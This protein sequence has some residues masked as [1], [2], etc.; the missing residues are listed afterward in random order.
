MR[1]ILTLFPVLLLALGCRQEA[2]VAETPRPLV[3]QYDRPAEYFEEALPI[4]NGRIGA[5][6]YGGTDTAV[7]TLNDITLWTGEPDRGL[8]HMDLAGQD[9]A[10]AVEAVRA[11]LEAE[12]YPLAERLQKRLQGHYSETYQPLGILRIVWETPDQVGGD[13]SNVMPGSDRASV[14][15]YRRELNISDA[16]A[17]V[18]YLRD[19]E[20]FT[21][22]AFASAPDSA[23]V[24]RLRY[25][26]GIHARISFDSP[27]PGAC[28]EWPVSRTEVVSEGGSCVESADSRT[29]SMCYDGYVAYHAY[30]GYYKSGDGQFLYDP[31]RGIHFRTLVGVAASSL[32]FDAASSLRLAD[33]ASSLSLADAASSLRGR[34]TQKPELVESVPDSSFGPVRTAGLLGTSAA[35][36]SGS[37]PLGTTNESRRTAGLLGTSPA[38]ASGSIVID[39]ASEVTIFVVNATS[40]NGFDKDPVREG[41]PYQALAD[42]NMNAISRCDYDALLERHTT[43]YRKYFD[44]VSIDLGTTADSVRVLPTDV[45]LRRYADLGEANPELEALYYQYGRYLLISSSRTPGVPA[46]LQGLWNESMDPPWSSNYTTNINLEE[47]Y[48][49]AETAALPEMHEVLLGFVRNLSVTG[50]AA[51]RDIYGV[52]RGW[53]LGQNS[54]IWAAAQPVGLGEGDPCWANW[55]MGGAWLSTHL[56]EHWLYTRDRDALERDYPAL[57][58]AAEFCLEWLVEKDGELLTSPGTSPE[59]IYRTPGGFYGA[60]LYGG[61]ADLAM[62]RECLR[63]AVAAATELGRDAAFVEEAS[64]ALSRLRGYHVADDGSLMEWY[65]CDFMDWD[66]RHRH[67]S[68][69]FG[70][71]PGHQISAEDSLAKAALKTLEIKGFETTGWSCGWRINLYARLGQGELAYKMYRR[72]LRYVSPDGYRG[73]DARRGGG[74]YPNLLDAHSPFQIDGNFGGCAGV[75]EMLLQSTAADVSAGAEGPSGSASCSTSGSASGTVTPLPALPSGSALS[76]GTV[77]PLP[78]LPSA[79]PTGHIHGLRTRA[80]TT[81]DLDW[82]DGQLVS[83]REY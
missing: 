73:S 44:R 52:Q 36:A 28:V 31:D 61:T 21:M 55:T 79:W 56:W 38:P 62:V 65:R 77:A 67:Q 15:D 68:H 35:P 48:W 12:D 43:D 7:F 14:S 72:L 64:A 8:G 1:K 66:P 27:Q 17:T 45:Q 49:P 10:G 3:L 37:D 69:L 58:G 4:G 18:S 51:A 29:V 25:A 30:P 78:A 74:T 46:N 53:N 20:P 59:N 70:V 82:A 75:M 39:G 23:I 81:V 40:F 54:D 76:S 80:G 13:D 71:Y 83:F 24:I 34:G 6:V 26:P 60:T 42:A 41:T 16:T 32:P 2:P 5:M 47:N 50:R 33:A 22:E 19:G 9:Y 63:D 57:R 11:A